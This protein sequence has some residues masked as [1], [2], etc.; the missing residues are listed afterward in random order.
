MA[1]LPRKGGKRCRRRRRLR[2]G[3]DPV[4]RRR[5]SRARNEKLPQKR[6]TNAR[7][8]KR[9]QGERLPPAQRA[10]HNPNEAND[11]PGR[12]AGSSRFSSYAE[13]LTPQ[14]QISV[15]NACVDWERMRLRERWT[16]VRAYY[17]LLHA[18]SFRTCLFFCSI[19]AEKFEFA[20]SSDARCG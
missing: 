5:Q 6:P 8:K 14:R 18:S 3:R 17:P 9:R 2:G 16:A 1:R 7:P 15:L 11:G 13:G 20:K 4:T 12:G 19:L 10:L